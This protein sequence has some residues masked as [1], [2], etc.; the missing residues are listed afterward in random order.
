MKALAGQGL[1]VHVEGTGGMHIK[2]AVLQTT[3]AQRPSEPQDEL[4]SCST[5]QTLDEP[6][7]AGSS[8]CRRD[9][10]RRRP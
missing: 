3:T 10:C 4:A 5:E 6:G 9:P 7:M 2:Y 8:S 1:V